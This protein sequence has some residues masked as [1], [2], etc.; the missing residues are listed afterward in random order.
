MDDQNWLTQAMYKNWQSFVFIDKQLS[1]QI[2]G[3][4]ACVA[5]HLPL[6]YINTVLQTDL[7]IQNVDQAIEKIITK[8]KEVNLDFSWSISP[9]TNPR[10]L[11]DFLKKYDFKEVNQIP[12]MGLLH[13]N[14]DKHQFEAELYDSDLE[15][16]KFSTENLDEYMNLFSIGFGISEN[17][18]LIKG[19][20]SHINFHTDSI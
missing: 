17:K 20:E 15:I 8:Y 7:P 3:L 14:I 5:P 10:N 4:T 9:F 2:D 19:F 11:V 1:Y 16:I 12:H 6:T 13:S 18:K